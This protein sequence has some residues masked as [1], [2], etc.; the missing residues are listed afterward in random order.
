VFGDREGGEWLAALS[1][2]HRSTR[3]RQKVEG[4]IEDGSGMFLERGAD[5]HR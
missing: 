5:K 3:R 4:E 2:G 1:S